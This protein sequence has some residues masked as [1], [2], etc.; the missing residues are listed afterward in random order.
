M[1][2]KINVSD[3]FFKVLMVASLNEKEANGMKFTAV[4]NTSNK[5]FIK[6]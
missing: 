4:R 2:W 1:K 5:H 6:K 3:R